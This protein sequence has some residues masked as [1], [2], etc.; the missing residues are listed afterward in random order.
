[1]ALT[2]RILISIFLVSISLICFSQINQPHIIWEQTYGGTDID[3]LSALQLLADGSILVA[4]Y[5]YSNNGDVQSGNNGGIDY[6]V[7]KTS[8]LGALEWEKTYGGSKSDVL[9]CVQLASDGGFILGGHTISNDGDIQ[10]GYNFDGDIWV[11]KIDESGSIVWEQ[12]YGGSEYEDIYTIVP[13]KDGGYLL[14][15]FTWSSDGDIQSGNKGIEDY[16][17]IKID[18]SGT[19]EWENTYGGSRC[20][21]I[22]AKEQKKD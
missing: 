6:W 7:A 16:L 10:S 21:R 19:I 9:R 3:E 22:F 11:V 15:G 1:M 18:V 17:I 12:T 13:T 4:G 2:M 20:F 8:N 5:T 14:G